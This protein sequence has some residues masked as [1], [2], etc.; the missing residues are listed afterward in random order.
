MIVV[1][2][3]ENQIERAK[4]RLEIKYNERTISEDP[5]GSV[6]IGSL[7][8]IIVI[9]FLSNLG[10]EIDEKSTIHY[11]IVACNSKI[12]IKTKKSVGVPKLYFNAFVPD[13]SIWHDC[14]NYIFCTIH[15]QLKKGYIFGIITKEKF[16]EKKV[17]AK[18][19]DRDGNSNFFFKADTWY[20]PFSD[21]FEFNTNPNN[22]DFKS[23][24]LFLDNYDCQ[25]LKGQKFILNQTETIRDIRSFV[26][27][28]IKELET[29]PFDLFHFSCLESLKKEMLPYILHIR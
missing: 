6:R 28:K 8:E 26:E 15:E 13:C 17:L 18:K 24:K 4:T 23:I 19:G 2:I 20:V 29:N 16:F 1:D 12:E 10:M 5:D 11:D 27:S 9:D 3:N 25:K 21:L 14:D 22:L 7:G